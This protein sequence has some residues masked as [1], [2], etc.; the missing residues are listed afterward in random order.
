LSHGR[1]RLCGKK[2]IFESHEEKLGPVYERRIFNDENQWE[3]VD[4]LHDGAN[5]ARKV[6]S[7]TMAAVRGAMNL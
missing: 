3:V 2:W 1:N 5:R 6:E 4:V 7:E